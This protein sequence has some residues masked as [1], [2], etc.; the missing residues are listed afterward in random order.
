MLRNQ[1]VLVHLAED[2]AA[3]DDVALLEVHGLVQPLAFSI[4]LANANIHTY[5]AQA[6]PLHEE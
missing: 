4:V 5:P 3:A 1:L 6:H 2:V